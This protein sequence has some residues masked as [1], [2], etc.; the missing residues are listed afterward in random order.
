MS[1]WNDKIIEEFRANAGQV[2]GQFAGAPMVLVHSRGRKT[3]REFVT[4][5]IYLPHA[6]DSDVIYIFAS[7]AG[8]PEH[9]EWYHN[10]VAADQAA[11]EVGT[12]TYPVRVRDLTGTERDERYNE[13]ASRFANFAEYGEKTA[14]IRTIPV[15]ELTRVTG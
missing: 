7:K 8:A 15:L 6:S 11:V 1:D 2:G 4:P 3:G 14:G 13:Q 10:L 12:E 9:P 5:L